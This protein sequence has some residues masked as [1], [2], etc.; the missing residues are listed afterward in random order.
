[1]RKRRA[2]GAVALAAVVGIVGIVAAY[3]YTA[4][5]ARQRGF[6]FGV[7]LEAIQGDVGDLQAGFYSD[8]ARWE[9]GEISRDE[10][11]VLYGEHLEEFAG[12]ISRYDGLDPPDIFRGSVGLLRLSS[13]TQMRSDEQFIE[14]M[15]TGDGPSLVRSDALFQ[16]S[17]EYELRGLVEFYSAKTGAVRYD[18]DGMFEPPRHNLGGLVAEVHGHMLAECDAAFAAGSAGRQACAAEADAWRDAHLP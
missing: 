8:K 10:L 9:E 15:R 17:L 12:I 16:E 13:E 3:G 6:E 1:M 7:E 5:Q 18:G 2:R 11:L 14:W 4:E